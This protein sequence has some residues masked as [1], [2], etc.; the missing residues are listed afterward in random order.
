MDRVFEKAAGESLELDTIEVEKSP[1]CKP[2]SDCWDVKL[3]FFNPEKRIQQ[4]RKIYRFTIDVSNI[5]PVTVG[6]IR[7][8]NI[9]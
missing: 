4:A 1:I 3:V 6:A 2:G 5:I 8:W 7:S 9:Y